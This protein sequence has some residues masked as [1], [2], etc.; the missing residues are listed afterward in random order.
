MWIEIFKSGKHTDSN[1]RSQ[2]YSAEDIARIADNYN[3]RILDNPSLKAPVVKGHPQSNEPAFGWVERLGRRGNKLIAD[4]KELHP[5][6]IDQVKKGMYRKVSISLYADQMLRHVGLL[7][8]GIPAVKG[9][10]DVKFEE[11][12]N[13]VQFEFEDA[14]T[15]EQSDYT[16]VIDENE[17]LK[18]ELETIRKETRLKEF[19]EYTNKLIDDENGPI[20]TP[21][22]GSLLVDILEMAF[23]RDNS[24]GLDFEE[25][26]SSV[27]RVR[28]FIESLQP[29][30]SLSEF[31]KKTDNSFERKNKFIGRNTSPERL[32]LHEM[33]VELQNQNPGLSYEEAVIKS[34]K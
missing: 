2:E 8:A 18:A 14:Q 26:T 28:E 10:A 29:V 19:R 25:I 11:M 23:D 32:K 15:D 4:L 16:D 3:S 9:L 12:E 31:A 6:I 21:V 33:A 1:G 30:I 5:D 17:K 22:Q 7:G 24:L 27:S 34:S 13:I 20:I